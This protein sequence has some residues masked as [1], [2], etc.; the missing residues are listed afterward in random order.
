MKVYKVHY[1]S[2][3]VYLWVIAENFKNAI[4]KAELIVVEK[5]I[6]SYDITDIQMMGDAYIDY[7]TNED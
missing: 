2:M 5:D 7:R 3:G 4:E 6:P 1:N